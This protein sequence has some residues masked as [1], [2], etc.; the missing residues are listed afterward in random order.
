[1]GNIPQYLLDEVEQ[2]WIPGCPEPKTV[3]DIGANIGAFSLAASKRWPRAEIYA[4]EPLPESVEE[5]RK[6]CGNGRVHIE[7]AAVRNFDGQRA[8]HTCDQSTGN[9][10]F[11]GPYHNDTRIVKVRDAAL[12]PAAEFIK[13]DTEGCEAE[14]IAR[15]P[16]KNAVGV[17]CEYHFEEQ[18]KPIIEACEQAG[19]WLHSD[20]R[21]VGT[22][23]LRFLRSKLAPAK[24]APAKKVFLALPIYWNVDP[25]F[26]QCVIRLTQ[27]LTL[28]GAGFQAAIGTHASMKPS[29]G[30]SAIGR[31]R[32]MLT[33]EFLASD[34]TDLLFIDSDLIFGT[35]HIDG[36]MEHD[37]PIVGGIYLKKQEGPP[38]CVM[39]SLDEGNGNVSDKGLLEVKYIGT[40][41]LRV[42]RSVFEKMIE[43][44]GPEIEYKLDPVHTVTEWDFWHM[45]V[46]ESPTLKDPSGKP[47]RRYLSEDWWFCQ[48][49]RD[50]GFKVYADTRIVLK[51]SGSAIYPLSYQEKELFPK[52]EQPISSEAMTVARMDSAGGLIPTVPPAT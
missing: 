45:G 11:K 7:T 49:A 19:L 26:F 28:K 34:C 37:E 33:R 29:V 12:L 35:E 42:N 1:M 38:Q 4:Y 39:N 21:N 15:L 27:E 24:V 3:L 25:H 30:D 48:K 18:V 17:T 5:F 51:H 23:I 16:L 13:I 47:L 32:N 46:Y 2:Y 41:F 43:V 50:L 14:I 8:I 22:G 10:F 40:G 36:I 31:A 52:E 6:N 44:H 9:S 20:T